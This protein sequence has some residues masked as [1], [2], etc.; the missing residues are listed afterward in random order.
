MGQYTTATAS[1]ILK[2]EFD[3][4][5]VNA[6]SKRNTTFSWFMKNVRKVDINPRGYFFSAKT[7]RNQG[8]GSNTSAQ[9]GGLMPRSGT[10]AY[11]KIKAEYQSH[12]IG[13]EMS[14]DVMDAKDDVALLGMSKDYMADAE[15]SFTTFQD[16][17]LFGNSS[18][19]LG[20]TSTAYSG[21][22][23]TVFTMALSSTRPYGSTK[24]QPTQRIQF[25][26]PATGTQRTGGSV[27][28]STVTAVNPATDVVTCDALPTDFAVSDIVVIEDTY[29]RE[30]NG[31][32]YYLNDANTTY[33]KDGE[34]GSAIT[35]S[36]NPWTKANVYDA[37]SSAI[38]PAF[39]DSIATQTTTQ[40]G[41]G[42]IAFD[43]VMVSHIAQ[44]KKYMALGYALT[45]NVEASGNKKLDLGFAKVSHNGME[46]RTSAN[47]QPDRILGLTLSTWLMPFVKLPQMYKFAS[48]ASLIQKPGT[49]RYYDAAQFYCYA[50]F[51]VVCNA[52]FQNWLIKGL[53]FD[54]NDVRI[55]LY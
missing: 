32:D 17:Y 20:V 26:D 44:Q 39:I 30:M 14:G 21:G 6:I 51:N 18:G 29:G 53:T 54:T 45:R 41:D 2:E 22:T 40:T 1:P 36:T 23:P 50:R 9:E 55:N 3:K 38:A 35:R 33:L 5:V 42:E 24:I 48:G 4:N 28:V 37:S 8:Y 43:A 12:F 52:P 7:R 13:G 49:D 19:S 25:I 15:E 31:F 34:T 47:C 11:K 10:P 46:W 16:F 27:T